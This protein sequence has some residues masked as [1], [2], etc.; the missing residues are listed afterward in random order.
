MANQSIRQEPEVTST[1][2]LDLVD[3]LLR[4]EKLVIK[5]LHPTQE[6]PLA[7]HDEDRK[8]GK[9]AE[10]PTDCKLGE[11]VQELQNIED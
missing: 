7:V 11:L 4:V 9:A 8:D 1:S 6:A 2:L 5:L 3:D 10:R